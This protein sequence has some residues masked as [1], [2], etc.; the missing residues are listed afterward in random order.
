MG[1]RWYDPDAGDFTSANT[2][3]VSPDP[4]EAA[5]NPFAYAADE[6]LDLVDPTGHYIVPEG[7]AEGAGTSERIGNGATS[8]SN[9]IADQTTARIVQHAVI[10]APNDAAKAAAARAAVAKVVAEQANA[11]KAAVARNAALALAKRKAATSKTTETS[12]QQWL[13]NKSPMSGAVDV[14]GGKN[15]TPPAEDLGNDIEFIPVGDQGV[16]TLINPG[17]E[18]PSNDIL[19]NPGHEGPSN[20]I[21]VTPDNGGP[22]TI[23]NAAASEADQPTDGP[24]TDGPGSG[25]RGGLHK[26]LVDPVTGL[27]PTGIERNHIPPNSINGLPRGSGPA[28]QMDRPDHYGTA[29]WGSSNEAIQYRA[30]QKAL[31]DQGNYG[32]AIQMDINDIQTSYGAKYDEAILEMIDVLPEEW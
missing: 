13:L 27:V 26:D 28:I 24:V 12:L 6:P 15:V 8:E 3:H 11:K 25:Y 32:D 14:D 1:A 2:V 30:Q 17:H 10:S 29:S 9:F 4:D 23:I 21:L 19:I 20:D 16:E 22:Q 7:G 31:I 5:G 18:G